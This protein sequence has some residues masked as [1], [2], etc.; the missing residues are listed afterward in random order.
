MKS[1]YKKF[2]KTKT[3]W[4]TKKG[5]STSPFFEGKK[6][7]K[8]RVFIRN[9]GKLKSGSALVPFFEG[10]EKLENQSIYKKYWKTKTKRLEN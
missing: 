5:L 3:N 1:I 7:W 4:K 6:N 8:M 2:W 9:I 10:E